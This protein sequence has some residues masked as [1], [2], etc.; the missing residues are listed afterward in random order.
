MST[1]GILIGI[2]SVLYLMAIGEG[3]K[4]II[5]ADIEKLV[6]ILSIV[7]TW[8]VVLSVRWI[9]IS[10]LFSIFMG[11][12]FGVYPAVRASQMSPIE[13]LRTDT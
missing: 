5:A 12:T 6:R 11:I 7:E 10:V 1:L 8:P 3:A 9:V 13:A 2:A 4:K